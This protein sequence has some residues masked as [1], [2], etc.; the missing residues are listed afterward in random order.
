MRWVN[1][2]KLLKGAVGLQPHVVSGE[3]TNWQGKVCIT[4]LYSHSDIDDLD[5]VDLKA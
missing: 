5:M 2:L 3:N 4:W 1:P